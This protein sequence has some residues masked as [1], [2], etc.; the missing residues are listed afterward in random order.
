MKDSL[1]K[2]ID[3]SVLCW[4]A[5]SNSENEPNVSPKEMF[6]LKDDHT[7][8]I[9][10]LASPISQKNIQQNPKVCVSMVNVFSQKGLKIKGIAKDI[11]KN[12]VAFG[13][14]KNLF[15][16]TLPETFE[17]KSF[18]EISIETMHSIVA[19]SYV[20]FPETSEENQIKAAHKTYKVK[21]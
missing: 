4:L 11:T 8:I 13:S 17:I 10:N 3:E 21:A 14:L 12:D 1:L 6:V 5:T 2:Y 19:P 20:L 18:F 9:A 15:K 7:L 16:D